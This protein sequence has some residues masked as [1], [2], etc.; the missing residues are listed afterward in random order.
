MAPADGPAGGRPATVTVFHNRR[1]LLLFFVVIGI[2]FAIQGIATGYF[3]AVV[4]TDEEPWLRN[5]AVSVA[6][7]LAWLGWWF[8][9]Q[10]WRRLRDPEDPIVIGPAGLR[11][12]ALAPE[13][14]PWRDLSAI[15]VMTSGKGG[16]YVCFDLAEGAMERAG[17]PWRMRVSRPVNRLFGHYD[18]HVHTIGTDAS[19]DRLADAIAP[20]AEVAR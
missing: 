16:T 19:P 3:F 8:A 15:R 17:M 6:A 7:F 9:S 20:F 10:A 12:R 13:T 1:W 2:G 18:F 5:A 14:M 11:D 4:A